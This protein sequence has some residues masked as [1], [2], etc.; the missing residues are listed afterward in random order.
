MLRNWLSIFLLLLPVMIF[1]WLFSSVL[2][3]QL[4]P[5]LRWIEALVIAACVTATDPVLASAVVGK[6]K[7]ARRVPGYLRNLLSAESGCNDGMA[8]PFVYLALS[9]IKHAGQARDIA[10]HFIVITLLY[11][12]LFG[13]ILGAIIGY[14]GRLQRVKE[15]LIGYLSWYFILCW[16]FSALG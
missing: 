7:F 5:S 8:L 16:L 3:W 2:I 1:G 12:C 14:T 10:F 13:T 9:C 11:K 4:V 6:G 15:L